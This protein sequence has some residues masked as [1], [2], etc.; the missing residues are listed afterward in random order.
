MRNYRGLTKEGKW[1]Y[2]WYAEIEEKHCIITTEAQFDYEE[3]HNLIFKGIVEVIP[4]T[5]GQL[6][7]LQ[8]KNDGKILDWWKGD[9]LE[10]PD[11]TKGYIA[12]SRWL[13]E[14]SIIDK[15]KERIL[16]V[17]AAYQYDWKKIGNIHENPELIK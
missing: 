11:G 2:G 9:V 6:T 4:E 17:G 13:C 3:D 16:S 15:C 14:W 7:G 8:D 10:S 12:Y 5:V 1:V